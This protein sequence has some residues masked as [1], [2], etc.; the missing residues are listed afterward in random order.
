M[1]SI[2]TKKIKEKDYLYLV[3]SVREGSKVKQK[4]VKYIGRKRPVSKEEFECMEYSRKEKDWVLN[5]FKDE[6][7]YQ[8]HNEMKVSSD[9]NKES[10]VSLD[11]VSKEKMKEKFL[12]TFISNSSAIEGSTLTVNETFN[13][14]FEDVVPEGH[15][16]KELF[17][18]SNILDAWNYME[19][20]CDKLPT[21]EDLCV[22]H[23]IV[24]KGIES[25]STLGQYKKVQNYIG[26]VYTTS[27][28]FV[29]NKMDQLLEWIKHSNSKIN[30]FETAFQSHAQFE[31]IHPFV[32]G[33]GR[34]GRLLLNWLLMYKNLSPLAIHFNKRREYISALENSRRGKVEAICLFMRDEYLEMYE[35]K[36]FIL[37]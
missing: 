27:Y 16:K 18:V 15:S 36:E 28:L 8:D 21:K 30:N 11:E 6:L 7:S 35:F 23:K 37:I 20:R 26:E 13:Y 9:K 4:T 3:E 2:V 25:D 12:S 32:D 1:A 29:D 17:M 31:I 34:V 24:N 22:L 5:E 14:L 19:K 33:N 10:L